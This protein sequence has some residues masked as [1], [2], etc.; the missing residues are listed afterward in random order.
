MMRPYDTGKH[1][2]ARW[3]PVLNQR[4]SHHPLLNPYRFA[5]RKI[6]YSKDMCR[7]SLE[8]MARS[9]ALEVPYGATVAEARATA[10][11]LLS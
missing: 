11:K 2:Y 7:R 3:E 10:R 9:V 5:K 1:V 4:G 8:I 6:S